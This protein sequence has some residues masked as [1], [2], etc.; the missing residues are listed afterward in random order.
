M[1]GCGLPVC[2]IS[3]SCIHEL[4]KDG[5]NGLLFSDSSELASQL[6]DIFCGFPEGSADLKAHSPATATTYSPAFA[7]ST[8]SAPLSTPPTSPTSPSSAPSSVTLLQKLRSGALATGAAGKWADE[9]GVNVL[10]LVER[11]SGGDLRGVMR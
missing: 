7:S 11:L 10:P 2:A 4:V 9:W 6:I 8:S 3:Y 1:F 5:T